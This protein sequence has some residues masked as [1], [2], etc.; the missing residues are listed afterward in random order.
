MFGDDSA[1]S[2]R[3][4]RPVIGA[5]EGLRILVDLDDGLEVRATL[6]IDGAGLTYV[7]SMD[8]ERARAVSDARGVEHALSVRSRRVASG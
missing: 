8:E 6:S 5:V 3:D 7:L 2:S 1:G 4:N